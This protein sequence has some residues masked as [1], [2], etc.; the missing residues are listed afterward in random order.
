MTACGGD[1]DDEPKD[2]YA[3]QQQ[4]N[5][6]DVSAAHQMILHHGQAIEDAAGLGAGEQRGRAGA[7]R[8]H[9]GSAGS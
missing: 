3:Q 6:A 8:E 7:C 4:L 1:S 2:Q 9:R 5:D